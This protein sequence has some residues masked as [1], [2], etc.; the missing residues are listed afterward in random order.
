MNSEDRA[1]LPCT[2]ASARVPTLTMNEQCALG[3]SENEAQIQ[4]ALTAMY[5]DPEVK[6]G[7]A[8]LV[9]PGGNLDK[10]A[11]DNIS[12]ERKEK[13]DATEITMQ[14]VQKREG[15]CRDNATRR[16]AARVDSGVSFEVG[17]A[18]SFQPVFDFI[19]IATGSHG[20][21]GVDLNSSAK[22]SGYERAADSIPQP[23]RPRLLSQE[24][25]EIAASLEILANLPS[26][27][28]MP[29]PLPLISSFSLRQDIKPSKHLCGICGKVFKRAHNLKIHGRLHTGDKPYAC[30]FAHCEKDF[31]WKSSLVSHLNWHKTK[32]DETLPG[33]DGTA[34]GCEITSD[35][36]PSTHQDAQR[37]ATKSRKMPVD[38]LNVAASSRLKKALL[39]QSHAQARQTA[40]IQAADDAIAAANEAAA[41][42]ASAADAAARC[43]QAEEEV[44]AG[45]WAIP[46]AGKVW[47]SP[48]SQ[49]AGPPSHASATERT[50]VDASKASGNSFSWLVSPVTKLLPSHSNAMGSH[51]QK[52][53]E[54]L[55]RLQ[56]PLSNVVNRNPAEETAADGACAP[57]SPGHCG[58]LLF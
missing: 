22:V 48:T 57:P 55:P 18:V 17:N 20:R 10:L 28:L 51:A 7:D 47:T 52:F 5:Y 4:A 50:A 31:R 2:V 41:E 26:D 40:A 49:Q 25:R 27:A 1:K 14:R 36:I 53:K 43:K 21:D 45:E 58:G 23:S 38:A 37:K 32:M 29:S 15:P 46:Y 3:N 34:Q 19:P 8:T 56:D 33:F 11:H 35:K 30:P 16:K 44:V 39:Q 9:E 13:W 6:Q 24:D 12:V 42:A 54:E